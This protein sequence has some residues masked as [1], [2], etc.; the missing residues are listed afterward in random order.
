[1]FIQLILSIFFLLLSICSYGK[2]SIND[3]QIRWRSVTGI[4]LNPLIKKE[5]PI[6]KPKN[7]WTNVLELNLLNEKFEIYK[8]CVLYKVPESKGTGILKI[9]FNKTGKTCQSQAFEPGDVE[10]K[11]IFNFGLNLNNKRLS[12]IIDDKT[13]HFQFPN[14]NLENKGL[15]LGKKI[16][17]VS[18]QEINEGDI[19][20]DFTDSCEPTQK[21]NCSLCP[22]GTVDAVY[23]E[24]PG[25]FRKYCSPNSCG[26]KGE[27]ACARGIV[28]TK[29][30]GD[31]CIPDSPI[32][33]CRKGLRVIC[34]NG[35]LIC[36]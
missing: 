2:A 4:E 28:S 24:C 32:G 35:E 18:N 9:F 23:T 27:Y 34:Q 11:G 22:T 13:Y 1:M 26:G 36:K 29:Y 30:T 3:L 10:V 8:D 17:N 31:L 33:F 14:L 6:I 19:C 20:L 7:T 5:T 21:F 12:F 15:L 25:T 16:K